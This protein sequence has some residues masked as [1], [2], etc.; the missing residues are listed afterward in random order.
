[1]GSI[2][3]RLPESQFSL[4][5]VTKESKKPDKFRRMIGSEVGPRPTQE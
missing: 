5:L 4:E 2:E 1:M 3:V